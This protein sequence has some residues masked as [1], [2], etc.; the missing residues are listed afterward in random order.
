MILQG[1]RSNLL[2]AFIF[3]DVQSAFGHTNGNC[4]I[5]TLPQQVKLQIRLL[6]YTDHAVDNELDT[7]LHDHQFKTN[8]VPKSDKSDQI[9]KPG[10]VQ[11]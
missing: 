6:W 4:I 11:G 1:F 2:K 10:T 8:Y 3:V 9:C 7:W 5:S